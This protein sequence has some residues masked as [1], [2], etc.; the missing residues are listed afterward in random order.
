M[1]RIFFRV[2]S[3]KWF[4]FLVIIVFTFS[5]NA[6]E[7]NKIGL[8]TIYLIRHG[9][10]NHHDKNDPYTGKGLV[11]LGIAQARLVA[12]RLKN[13]P[14]IFSS[15]TS[16]TMTRARQT[17]MIINEEFPDLQLQQSELIS[18]CTMPTWR[19]DIMEEENPED[20]IACTNKLDSVFSIYFTP[21][22]DENDRNDIL[23]C[24]GNV[25][26]YFVT[27]VLMVESLSWLQMTITNCSL[28]VV[29][30]KPDGTM[31]LLSFNDIGHIP[32]N[33]QTSTGSKNEQKALILP[34]E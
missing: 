4:I 26:R 16:S 10:Y 21:S 29:K 17:G 31:K 3:I 23:V 20:L 12:T 14:V 15:I 6:Q 25:I 2:K 27:K 22:P 7:K 19:K 11:P 24:H 9:E 34:E 5:L 30:I 8:R 1:K 33:M 28:T 18:E 13:L 32:P